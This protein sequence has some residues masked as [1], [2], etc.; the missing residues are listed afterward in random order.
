MCHKRL[1]FFKDTLS[2]FAL[3]PEI[4]FGWQLLNISPNSG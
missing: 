4:V 3:G 1:F 2:A